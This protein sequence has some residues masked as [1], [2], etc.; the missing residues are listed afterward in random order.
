MGIHEWASFHEKY[1]RKPLTGRVRRVRA[2]PLAFHQPTPLAQPA[3][4]A[5]TRPAPRANTLSAPAVGAAFVETTPQLET[6]VPTVRSIG[7]SSR[8][9][10]GEAPS[11]R[12][13][14]ELEV[15]PQTEI[16]SRG[17]PSLAM[18][19][20]NGGAN[21]TAEATPVVRGQQVDVV[22]RRSLEA[23]VAVL[24]GP[25][26]SQP[27]RTSSSVEEKG[28][29]IM[30]DLLC[31]TAES[32]AFQDVNDAELSCGV[33]AMGLKAKV[34]SL[35]AELEQ[36]ATRV[37]ALSE[38]WM[39]K[40]AELERKVVEMGNSENAR[41]SA[42]ARA[43]ALE[44]TFRVLQSEQESERATATLREARLEERIGEIDREV[45]SL[46]DRVVALEA[47]RAQLLAQVES[48][49]AA[50]PCHLHEL[51]VHVEAQRNIYKG[52]W[53]AGN[54]S[55][56]AVEEAWAKA[57]EACINCGYDPATLEAGDDA[58]GGLL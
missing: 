22:E 11:K 23:T 50:V 10:S 49:S 56:A 31:S 25:S 42:L 55:K 35:Q 39:G 36:N 33:A 57:H 29:G 24:G 43:A 9:G 14:V 8:A 1:G 3:L 12:R 7:E 41:A 45:S 5:A 6:L 38:E 16:S 19:A 18:P 4:R 44:D 2:P 40:L 34:L 52:L 47:E 20:T 37:E 58:D 51:W 15:A 30:F 27:N 13:W 26:T 17:D 28:K 54:V 48:A 53:E 46:G 32:G 21:P